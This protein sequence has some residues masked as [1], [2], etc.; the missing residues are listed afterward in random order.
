[1]VLFPTPVSFREGS[2]ISD[3]SRFERSLEARLP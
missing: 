2:Q 1:V 3:T